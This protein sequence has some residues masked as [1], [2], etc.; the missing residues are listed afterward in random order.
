[1]L[2]DRFWSK[3]DKSGDCWL[4]TASRGN[5]GE[6]HGHYSIKGRKYQAHRLAFEETF[7]PIPDGLQVLHHCDT[8]GC[9]N[10]SHLFLGTQS[11]NMRDMVAKGR[12]HLAKLNQTQV[13]ELRALASTGVPAH[14]LS[15]R[16]HVGSQQVLKIVRGLS[17]RAVPAAE[18]RAREVYT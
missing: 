6:W 5:F 2:G 16:F 10:P 1:V 4:W 17:W 8:R 15:Q 12:C 18:A 7:G 14:E 13:S 11:D 9:V 3:V